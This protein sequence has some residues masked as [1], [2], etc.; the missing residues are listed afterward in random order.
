M[1]IVSKV[2]IDCV[3]GVQILVPIYFFNNI[4]S[5]VF[6]G[7]AKH[8]FEALIIVVRSLGVSTKL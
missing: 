6:F 7:I 1:V 3:L 5:N 4:P 8:M 2:L